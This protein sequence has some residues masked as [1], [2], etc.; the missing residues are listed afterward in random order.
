M[1]SPLIDIDNR[2]NKLSFSFLVFDKEFN[3]GNQLIDSF[4]DQF[5]F[6]PHSSNIKNHIKNLNNITFRASSNTSSSIIVSNASIKNHI[7]TS[8]SHIHLHNKPVIKTIHRAVNITTTEAEL[9]TIQYGINQVVGITNINYIIVISDSL[10]TAKRIFDSSSHPYQIHSA[11]TS[12]ELRGFFLKD[13]NNCIKFWDCPSK[14]NW[15]LH[16]LVDK[17]SKSFDSV[18]IFL[19]KLS[20]DYCKKQEC[21]SILSQWKMSFQVLDLKG[22]NFLKLLDS[23]FKPSSCWPLKAVLGCNILAIPTC[24]MLELLEPSS[25]ML[26][27]AN[28]IWDPSLGKISCV[29]AVYILLKLGDT[30]CMTARDSTNIGILEGIL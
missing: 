24:C 23:D 6:Y 1:S 29:H 20:W 30:S 10:H 28:I 4:S 22:K 8:I 2:C 27:S 21:N 18:P 12:H 7:A 15:L 3:P 26:P 9:F 19:C 14:Q 25:I 11:A 16:S 5:Y 17:D 13:V